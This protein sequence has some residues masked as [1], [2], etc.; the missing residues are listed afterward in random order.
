MILNLAPV[1]VEARRWKVV[2]AAGATLKGISEVD[3]REIARLHGGTV[4]WQRVRLL[5]DGTEIADFWVR[6]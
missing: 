6:C 2:L 3:A 1:L 5:T 4:S